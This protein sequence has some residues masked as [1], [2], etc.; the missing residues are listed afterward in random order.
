LKFLITM[1]TAATTV[2]NNQPPVT[3]QVKTNKGDRTH[4]N[5]IKVRSG[6]FRSSKSKEDHLQ[7]V[8]TQQPSH[9]F[10]RQSIEIV[11]DETCALFKV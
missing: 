2:N 7:V 6:S 4:Y 5:Y 1:R 10:R 8:A 3:E 9:D 11:D